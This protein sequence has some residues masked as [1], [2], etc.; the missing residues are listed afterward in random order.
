[1]VG[2]TAAPP[3]TL[4]QASQESKTAAHWLHCT[5]KQEGGWEEET[6]VVLVA[7]NK[8]GPSKNEGASYTRYLRFLLTHIIYKGYLP[9]RRFSFGYCLNYPPPPQYLDFQYIIYNR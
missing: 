1:M 6:H 8:V 5:T 7:N 3:L 9:K 2:V 4:S